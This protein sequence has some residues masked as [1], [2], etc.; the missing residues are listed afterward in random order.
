MS[1]RQ[2]GNGQKYEYVELNL[3]KRMIWIA[4]YLYNKYI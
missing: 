4:S 3:N 2:G 1:T